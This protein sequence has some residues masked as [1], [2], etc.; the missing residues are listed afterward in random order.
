MVAMSKRVGVFVVLATVAMLMGMTFTASGQD[1]KAAGAKAAAPGLTFEVYKDKGGDFRYR[2]VDDTGTNLGGSGK[3]Y[4]KKEDVLKVV[5]TIK[6]DAGT[7][8]I[9]DQTTKK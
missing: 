2:I 4:D 9:D 1:K 5:N 8:K 3:G 6:K 7:A